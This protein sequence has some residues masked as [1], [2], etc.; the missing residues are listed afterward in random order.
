MIH[1]AETP[2]EMIEVG[3]SFGRLAISGSVYAL[4]GGLGTGKTHWT[5]GFLRAL[6]SKAEVTSPT[7]GLIH[8]Y[9]DGAIPVYHFDFYRM[10]SPDEV[11]ALGWD[12]IVE[13]DA[14]IVV[15]WANLFPE[16]LP[17][18]TQWLEFTINEDDSRKIENTT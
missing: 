10:K 15:E 6:G 16:L 9:E 18:D 13:D 5:K 7:F 14:V 4:Q 11:L 8:Q 17:T 3:A 2:L 1:R 12:E